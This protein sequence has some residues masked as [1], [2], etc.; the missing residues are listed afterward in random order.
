MNWPKNFGVRVVFLVLVVTL[1]H[2]SSYSNFGLRGKPFQPPLN[3]SNGAD[4]DRKLITNNEPLVIQ[5]Q[6][7]GQSQVQGQE[8]RQGRV[9]RLY[10]E[11]LRYEELERSFDVDALGSGSGPDSDSWDIRKDEEEEPMG[12]VSLNLTAYIRK[13]KISDALI[14][15]NVNFSAQLNIK[16]HAGYFIVNETFNTNLFFWY[17]PA[18]ENSE[19]APVVLSLC[20]DFI[21][22]VLM[23][24]GPI[25]FNDLGHFNVRPE[26]L[27]KKHHVI[28]IDHDIGSNF[29]FA[30]HF[31]GVPSTP[32][33]KGDILLNVLE[34]FYHLF[35]SLRY[36]DV[37]V[38]GH[39]EG[40]KLALY[41]AQSIH[42]H[43]NRQ[44]S[45]EKI[46]LKGIAIGS[47]LIDPP[48][49]LFFGRFLHESGLIDANGKSE[50]LRMEKSVRDALFK[51]DYVGAFKIYQNLTG[52]FFR[53]LTGY[54]RPFNILRNEKNSSELFNYN[55][56]LNAVLEHSRVLSR[57][58]LPIFAKSLA[59]KA[60][61]SMIS[62]AD[63]VRKLLANYRILVYTGNLDILCSYRSM[64]V[65]LNA[66]SW[67]G[68][69]R[70]RNAV[71]LEW[72]DARDEVAGYVRKSGNLVEA[73][74]RNAGHFMFADQPKWTLQL[75]EYF[76]RGAI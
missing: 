76:F 74:V 58:S 38:S 57:I 1:E 21:E 31:R 61:D 54:A 36:N 32:K 30:N 65:W 50:Y 14:R 71:Q 7:Q 35:P 69:K 24:G 45:D 66:L 39:G 27:S 46:N 51:K 6:G 64:A 10:L 18:K 5:N 68:A 28:Y 13:G 17:F 55:K 72:R 9:R 12:I 40:S 15:S 23:H 62:Q 20:K 59:E 42:E 73:V 16:S 4:S 67:P 19:K 33:E 2:A 29:S 60:A 8:Q 25:S 70:F 53:R 52:S 34:Q 22:C 47:A 26:F 48:K 11:P 41:V 63:T 44:K 43:N 49:Q 3:Y 37:F 75:L 56:L